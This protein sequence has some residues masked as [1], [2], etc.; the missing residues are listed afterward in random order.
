MKVKFSHFEKVE[1]EMEV[2]LPFYYKE[3]SE[4]T[5]AAG[6]VTEEKHT[7]I[8]CNK[9]PETN[10]ISYEFFQEDYHSELFWESFL[11]DKGSK[12]EFDSIKQQFIDFV[13][14]I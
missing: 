3:I 13:K 4:F 14:G 2:E 11:Q 10:G 5:T 12:K 6:E 1:K 7:C 8:S 9:V